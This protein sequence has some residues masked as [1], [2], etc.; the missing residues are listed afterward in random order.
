LSVHAGEISLC[1]QRYSFR[2]SITRPASSL[3]PAPYVHC[4]VCTW[5]LLLTGWLGFGQVGLAPDVLTHWVTTTNFMRSLS[6]LRFRAYLGATTGVV[7]HG[8]D[9]GAR[10]F[11]FA[12]GFPCL[13]PSVLRAKG[14]N[15]RFVIGFR[16]RGIGE[17]RRTV[18]QQEV[19]E[20][21]P[22]LQ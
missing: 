19:A 3:P 7:R 17:M 12:P 18:Q 20:P 8:F 5:S 14:R 4:W 6:I 2:G 21:L 15:H 13:W 1:P 11:A 22:R 10:C 16:L 9:E